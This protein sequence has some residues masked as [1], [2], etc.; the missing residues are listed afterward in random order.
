M[1]QENFLVRRFDSIRVDS[2]RKRQG[3]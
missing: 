2:L 1:R 3:R